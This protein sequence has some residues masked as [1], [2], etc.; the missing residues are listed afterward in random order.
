MQLVTTPA[1]LLEV[2]DLHDRDR[3]VTV[4]TAGR[5]RVRGVA[6]GAKR[7]YSR[8]AGQLQP[9]SKV[10]LSWFEKE[11]RELVRITDCELMR[12]AS[13]LHSTLE[14]ILAGACF[15]DQMRAFAQE[16]EESEALFRL[17]D[18]CLAA[19]EEGADLELVARYYE[20]WVLRLAGIYPPPWSCP[21]C[22]H[23]FEPAEVAR[24]DQ[25]SQAL[26]CSSCA[27][28]G[29]KVS[30]PALELLRRSA[31]ENLIHW[32]QPMPSSALLHEL[33]ET[34]GQVRR[35]FLGHELKSFHVQA[36]TLCGSS[37]TLRK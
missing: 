8:F 21:Q 16:N 25:A 31:R 28:S 15:A 27:A 6:P 12:P 36:Q 24:F 30:A 32:R 33:E 5:G 37:G 35:A 13:R 11:G 19:L 3:I 7:K 18:T 1:L 17:L 34:A 26:L 10:R 22:G 29:F 20:I 14:G 23:T 2:Q 9:L 4:L